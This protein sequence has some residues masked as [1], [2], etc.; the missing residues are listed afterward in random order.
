MSA[1]R[2]ADRVAADNDQYVEI[3]LRSTPDPLM[4]IRH[5]LPDLIDRRCSPA[6]YTRAVEAAYRTMWQK[7]RGGLPG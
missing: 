4:T 5:E 6:A 7:Y 2:M 1:I 3:A